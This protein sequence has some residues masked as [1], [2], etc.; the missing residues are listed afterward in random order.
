MHLLLHKHQF[1]IKLSKCSFAKKEL[2]YLGHVISAK[3]VATDPTKVNIIKH[4]PTPTNVKEVRSFLGMA[5]Y[6]RKFVQGF[7]TIS[8]P[9]TSLLKKGSVFFWAQEQQQSFQTLKDALV[10]TPVLALPDLSKS[11]VIETDASDKGIGAVLQQNGHLVAYVS[12]A[13]GPNN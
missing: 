2:A 1:K 3:G 12:E 13:L 10:T 4:W 8:K 9:L 7:G 5:S 6:Y 11:F